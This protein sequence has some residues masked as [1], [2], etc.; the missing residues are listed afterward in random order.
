MDRPQ[1]EGIGISEPAQRTVECQAG[2]LGM[3]L[4]PTCDPERLRVQGVFGRQC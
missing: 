3:L 1:Q 2:R 4:R